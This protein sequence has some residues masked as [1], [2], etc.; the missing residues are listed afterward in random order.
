MPQFGIL[1]SGMILQEEEEWVGMKRWR[2][3]R[4]VEGTVQALGR[5][6][7]RRRNSS[8][9]LDRREP[10]P[11]SGRRAIRRALPGRSHAGSALTSG[12]R[13]ADDDLMLRPLAL[14]TLF[15]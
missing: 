6:L 7:N 15:L 4:V 11:V 13:E 8:L 10:A 12:G 2:R 14:T 9:Q 1:K 5:C 3:P